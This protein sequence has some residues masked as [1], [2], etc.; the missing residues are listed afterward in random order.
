MATARSR[1]LELF[2]IF[3]L[4]TLAA[5]WA[6][7][8]VGERQLTEYQWNVLEARANE[9][10]R[11]I[12]S[13]TSE[14]S[15]EAHMVWLH[16]MVRRALEHSL[17]QSQAIDA[18]WR[19][20]EGLVG[21][22]LTRRSFQSIFLLDTEGRVR[23]HRGAP[24]A[25]IS[26]YREAAAEAMQQRRVIF[27]DFV[28]PVEQGT[29][30]RIAM[31][32][33]LF[34]AAGAPL[35]TLAFRVQPY[36]Y[37]TA[38]V[39]EWPA[40][41]SSAEVLVLRPEGNRIVF[42]TQPRLRAIESIEA[43]PRILS[44]QAV[45]REG[46]IEGRDYRGVRSI[47]VGRRIPNTPWHLVAKV[48]QSELESLVRQLAAGSIVLML[49]LLA[50]G[51]MVAGSLLRRQA[52]EDRF[53]AEREMQKALYASQQR[54]IQ[55][56]KLVALGT[57]AAGMAH[58][59]NNPLMGIMNY[60][61]YVLRRTQD[62]ELLRPLER[63][64]QELK[65]IRDLLTS[66]LTFAAPPSGERSAFGV[67]LVLT[68]T[69]ELLG[70]EFRARGI[71]LRHDISEGLPRVL[72]QP[73][74][75]QQ[76]FVNLLLNARDAAADSEER[77]VL[78][79]AHAE[80]GTVEVEIRDSGR[81]IPPAIQGQI[82]DPFFTTKPPGQGTG[83]GLSIALNV[84]NELGGTIDATSHPEG[85]ASFTVRLPAVPAEA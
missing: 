57:L 14:R 85:G 6:L 77:T 27:R 82:F 5:G 35:G 26:P 48:D 32:L 64:D 44:A 47:G 67:G 73:G 81:G 53:R 25:D 61:S 51:A 29:E 13:W 55:S 75:L 45:K 8:S 42:I 54:L 78:L 15:E 65:R 3:A 9:R 43:S 23:Y 59:L 52:A 80:N 28:V 58:E 11:A 62:P 38:L 30:V 2:A 71:A 83:L 39:E 50:A 72:A 16:P 66:M 74:P 34:D 17:S 70:P 41:R 21:A 46:R 31:A 22:L 76:V 68:R 84:I 12:T 18:D 19:A 60:V 33:P 37:R 20:L 24:P 10:V 49:L 40:F 1:V 7:F 56:E 69:V 36:P 63:A 4:V 79:R